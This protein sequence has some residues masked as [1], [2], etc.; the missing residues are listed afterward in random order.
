MKQII[1]TRIVVL[2]DKLY[3]ITYVGI[4]KTISIQSNF[5]T[6]VHF[7]NIIDDNLAIVCLVVESDICDIKVTSKC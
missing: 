6:F 1:M 5:K 7:V 2:R 3:K 4:Y